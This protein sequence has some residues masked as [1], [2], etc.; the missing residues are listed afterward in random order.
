MSEWVDDSNPSAAREESEAHIEVEELP[1]TAR[2]PLAALSDA[3]PPFE[4]HQRRND[5]P[6]GI[7]PIC[8]SCMTDWP[9]DYVRGYREAQAVFRRPSR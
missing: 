7:G 6:L 4:V 3:P 1:R 2:K 5:D 8:G 9:C